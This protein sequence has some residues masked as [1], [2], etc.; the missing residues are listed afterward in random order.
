MGLLESGMGSKLLPTHQ[1]P[2]LDTEI[3]IEKSVASITF[4][5]LPK[6]NYVMILH[7]LSDTKRRN[8][9]STWLPAQPSI[10]MDAENS[11]RV[12]RKGPGGLNA[13][14]WRCY[15]RCVLKR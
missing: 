2:F 7:R 10:H 8:H 15:Q 1:T 14:V 9:T 11:D 6:R 5:S 13:P 4:V 3:P 12:I